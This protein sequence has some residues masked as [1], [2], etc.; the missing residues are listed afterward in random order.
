MNLKNK[1]TDAYYK[2]ML[3]KEALRTSFFELQAARDKYREMTANEEGLH[4]DLV[5][6][7]IELQCLLLSP[8]CPHVAEHV[9]QLIG[10]VREL[11]VFIPS[12]P[13]IDFL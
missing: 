10:K 9:F 4:H 6:Q 8:I 1:E 11:F 12:L 13:P 2:N 3:Y 5:F 7:F